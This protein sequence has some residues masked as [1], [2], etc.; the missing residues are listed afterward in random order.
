MQRQRGHI[1]A[2]ND[3]F[4]AGGIVKIR[5]G[6]MGFMQDGIGGNAGCKRAFMVGVAFQEIFINANP[7]TNG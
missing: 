7:A 3:F 2:E 1:G 5:H 6:L 4:R